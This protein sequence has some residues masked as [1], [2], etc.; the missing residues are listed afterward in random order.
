MTNP[1]GE[2]VAFPNG[3]LLHAEA[4][5]KL[6]VR[7]FNP[8]LDETWF[9]TLW[10]R[11]MPSR[12]AVSGEVLNAVLSETKLVLVAERQGCPVGI[13]AIDYDLSGEAG[14]VFLVVDPLWQGQGIGTSLLGAFERELK[15]LHIHVLRLG[16]VSTGTYLWPGMPA[17]M[18]AAWPFF[19]HRGWSI[20]EG[21]ADLVQKL[22]G[23]VTPAWL[24]E[25]LK[26][27][28]VSLRLCNSESRARVAAFEAEH[29]PVWSSYFRQSQHLQGVDERVLVAQGAHGD[30][31]GTLLMDAN[32]PRRW[33]T[34]ENIQVGSINA[35]GVAL[36][37]RQRGVGLAL[38]AKAMEVLQERGCAKCYVQWTGL[39]SWYGKLGTSVWADYRM[40]KKLL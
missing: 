37:S 23:F 34:D 36:G 2:P 29:F 11:T 38:A 16:A 3:V 8:I 4:S 7:A 32:V 40:A 14:L 27:S 19:E 9:E 10:L 5:G 26:Y 15:A 31:V 24:N 35:L 13:G 18:E 25:S 30:I 28:G 21:C 22:A 39:A 33:C 20:E 1:C 6:V 12:W 17:E